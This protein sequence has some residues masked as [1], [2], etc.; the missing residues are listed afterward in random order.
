MVYTFHATAEVMV[1]FFDRVNK[2]KKDNEKNR[3]KII[4]EMIK[5]GFKISVGQTGRTK[6]EIVKD[7]A[8]HGTV[9]WVKKKEGR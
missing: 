1:E 4:G 9:M 8:K 7:Y 5:E 6:E 3:I 2:L